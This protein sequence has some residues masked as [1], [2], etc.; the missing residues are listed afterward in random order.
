MREMFAAK[1]NGSTPLYNIGVMSRLT[2][3]PIHTLRW[4]GQ[5]GLIAPHRTRGNQ[6][7]Y[8]DDN[9]KRLLKIGDLMKKGV[10]LAGIRMILS[11]K[12]GS[13]KKPAHS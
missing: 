11:M 7:L 1:K 3:L 10:N 6:R 2:G 8:S 4:L 5:N 13:A 9:L 12:N